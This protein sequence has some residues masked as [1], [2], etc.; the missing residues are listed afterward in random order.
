MKSK[1]LL[2]M[3]LV[4]ALCISAAALFLLSYQKTLR[5]SIHPWP[6][7]ESLR[8]AEH[9]SWLPDKV[10]VVESDNATQSMALLRSGAVSAATLTLDEAILLKG[11]GLDVSVVAIMNE[12]IGA[13]VVISRTSSN[14]LTN[15]KGMRIALEGN[16][17]SNIVLRELLIETGLSVH[18]VSLSYLPPNEQV[19]QWQSERFDLAITYEPFATYL[20]RLGGTRV[21]D[22]GHFPNVIFDV[23]VIRNDAMWLRGQVLTNL[24]AGHFR[25]L[26]YIR[27]NR[28]D[29]LRRIAAWRELTYDEIGVAFNGLYL[30]DLHFN[31]RMLNDRAQFFE[32]MKQD[33]DMQGIKLSEAQLHSLL[34]PAYLYRIQ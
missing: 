34:Q 27:V 16:T 6:G 7:Y 33:R 3:L 9:F 29:A 28:E 26:E 30:P 23:L 20:E 4:L 18:D 2:G 13:D 22:S 32:A 31:K 12:S 21:F 8:L 11:E 1:L 17:V 5:V 14:E 10:E 19:R 15:I 25:A 24:L